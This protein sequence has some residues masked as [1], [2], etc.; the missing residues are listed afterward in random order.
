M[1][2]YL[3]LNGTSHPLRFWGSQR[4]VVVLFPNGEV[5]LLVVNAL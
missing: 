5:L 3:N 1:D 2:T 4:E